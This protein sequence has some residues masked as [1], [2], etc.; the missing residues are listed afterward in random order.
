MLNRL[1]R[2]YDLSGYLFIAPSMIFF[3]TFVLYPMLKGMHMSL[4]RFRGRRQL[5]VGLEN[6]VKLLSDNVFLRSMGNTMFIVAIAVPI[7]V[8]LSLFIAINIYNKSAAVRS[9][10]RGVFYLPAVS[11]VVSITVVWLWIYNPDFGI[12]NY[13]LKSMHVVNGNVQWLG[14]SATAIYA[15]IIVLIT[16]SIGQPIILYIAALG[17][18]PVELI[19]SAK[20]DGASNWVIFK[21]IIWPLIIPTTLYIVVT[22]T[23]NSFQ[24]FALI[25]LM[26]AGGPNY[27]TSTVMYLVY[28]T[29]IKIQDYGKASA[30]GVV[31]AAIIAVISTLQFKYLNR[32]ID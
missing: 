18:V 29:G 17:N 9:F 14:N 24:I 10:F 11:S 25:Q 22:T 4:F 8:V 3:V 12:L 31:L 13:V 7:V 5:F 19:E 21:N 30:M 26:T 20:I 2:K 23:I 1:K 6:Y 27:A 32:D 16:T 28:E 15:I